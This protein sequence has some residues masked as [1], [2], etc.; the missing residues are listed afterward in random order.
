MALFFGASE[1]DFCLGTGRISLACFLSD[2]PVWGDG[3]PF[4]PF[5]FRGAGGGLLLDQTRALDLY[6]GKGFHFCKR[7]VLHL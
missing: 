1:V 6:Y 2:S 4:E 5:F 7:N 3:L